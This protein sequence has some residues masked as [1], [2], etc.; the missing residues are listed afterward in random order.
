MDLWV[1]GGVSIGVVYC[2]A[3]FYLG[4]GMRGILRLFD[5]CV[6]GVFLSFSRGLFELF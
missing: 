3:I 4:Q 2:Q 6:S 5:V 1:N